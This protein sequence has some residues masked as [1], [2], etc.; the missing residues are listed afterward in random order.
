MAELQA[1]N[2]DWP[3][4][5]YRPDDMT[6][7]PAVVVDRPSVSVNVQHHIA[8]V[9]VVVIGRRDGTADAQYELDEVASRVVDLLAGPQFNV[10]RIEP[11]TASIAELTYPAYTVTVSCGVTYCKENPQ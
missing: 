1:A 4:Y 11:A 2:V 3:V 5:D 9:P 10:D 7:L 8:S 6:G